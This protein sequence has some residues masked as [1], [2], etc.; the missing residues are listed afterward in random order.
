MSDNVLKFPYKLKRTQLPLER[1]CDMA[2]AKLD[3]V[4]IAG[5]TKQGQVQLLSTFQDPAEVLYYL[6]TTKMG[7]MQG[8]VLVEEGEIDEE[9]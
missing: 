6:E 1:V 9:E 3:K 8:M 2:K 7:L 5:V 4:V